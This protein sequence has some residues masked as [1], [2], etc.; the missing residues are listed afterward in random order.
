MKV[1][2]Q[3][4]SVRDEMER[5]MEQTLRAV[6]AMGY[7]F[8]EFAGF[9]GHSA[10]EIKAMLQG[11][12]LE[13]VSVHQGYETFLEDPEAAAFLKTIGVSYCAVPYMGREKHKGAD[14]YAQTIEMLKKVSERL[15]KQGI[16]MLYHNHEFEFHTYEGKCL[17]DWLYETAGLDAIEPEFDTCWI[18]YAGYSPE[19]YLKQYSGHVPVV[20][21]KDF[22]GS[23]GLGKTRE[24]NGFQMQPVGQGVQDWESI[25]QAAKAA[26]ARYLI[27]EQDDNAPGESLNNAEKSRAYLKDLGY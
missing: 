8:V 17:I 5:D 16:S 19:A 12:G 21:I 14:D 3:L 11:I 1:G 25:L 18:K 13:A 4:Y 2:L 7:D 23:T 26:G 27:V 22:T 15:K 20:H 6:K 10:D 9:F 24:E